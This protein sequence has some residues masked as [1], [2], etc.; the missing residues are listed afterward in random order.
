MP[1]DR[2]RLRP[3]A[4]PLLRIRFAFALLLLN[5]LA[6]SNAFAVTLDALDPSRTY[7]VDAIHFSGNQ[8]F[9][10][11]DLEAAMS[12]KP[13]PLYALWQKRPVFD[14]ETFTGDLNQLQ[15]F[16]QSHGYYDAHI[17]YDL[18]I[19]DDLVTS[20]IKI[21]EGHPVKVDSVSVE[22]ASPAP[23][24]Q[25]LQ[26]SFSL[27]LEPG[28]VFTQPNYQ[29]GEQ[30]LMTVYRQNGYAH[31]DVQRHAVVRTGPHLAQAWYRVTPHAHGVFG[32]TTITGTR[33]VNPR[34]VLRE[35]AYRAGQPFDVR[36]IEKSRTAILNLNLFSAVEFTS[37]NDPHHP[38]V[39]PITITVQEKPQHSLTL[40]G[41]YNTQTELN[42]QIGWNDY[43]FFG[44]GRQLLITGTY[45]QITAVLE[46]QLIQPHFFSRDSRLVLDAS[47]YQESYQTYMLNAS[48]FDPHVD[49][50]FTPT[51]TG[52]L[53]YR[54]E[55]LKYNQVNP[56]T[57][58]A[59]GGFRRDGILSGPNAGLIFNN[60][61][62]LLNP[63]DGEILS[64]NGNFSD[65]PLGADYH[66]W[67]VESEARRYQPLGGKTILATRL[68]VGLEDTLNGKIDDV[69][70][71]ERFYSGGE[72]SVRGYGLR[73]IGPLS[74][75]NDPLGGLSL[76]ETSIELRHPLI[77]KLSG[78]AFFDCGQ[79]SVH[80]FDLPVDALQ[81]GYGPA[82]SLNTPVGPA[83]VDVGF[84]TKTPRDDS[85]YQFYFSI[86]QYF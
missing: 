4:R 6:F 10:D 67:R 39:V 52:T 49:Y 48:R 24:P 29:A 72:G 13:R 8:N 68:K 5:L 73:R 51:L 46:V 9:S 81:C 43:N 47:Q 53:G 1:S 32:L 83:R 71:S 38:H 41:G 56:T 12:T 63:Q 23:S 64:L 37:G 86:G 54:F 55:Y 60:T 77:W 76:I 15:L 35:L 45:S 70:L 59:I 80:S 66:Y 20:V 14:P 25:V 28:H 30:D 82:V 2:H 22:V 17:S 40:G 62:D 79:V 27:P 33:K 7:R 16:Y 50:N 34:I 75:S 78:A 3:S 21:R 58:E 44:D 74:L 84:P 69:P 31:P 26:P 11:G 85:S 65:H 19:H 57:I 18:E 42:A 61:T 36:K